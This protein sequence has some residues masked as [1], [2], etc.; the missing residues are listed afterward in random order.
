MGVML[1]LD[2]PGPARGQRHRHHA[3]GAV[4]RMMADV[5]AVFLRSVRAVGRRLRPAPGSGPAAASRVTLTGDHLTA[6]GQPGLALPG[7][8]RPESA[9]PGPAVPRVVLAG[10]GLPLDALPAASWT[11]AA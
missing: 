2:R 8:A 4:S 9:P 7:L 3:R 6:A 11:A 1:C 10:D 5:A